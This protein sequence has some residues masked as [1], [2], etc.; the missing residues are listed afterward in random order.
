[1]TNTHS[2]S[3]EPFPLASV[4]TLMSIECASADEVH[5]AAADLE[6]A[7][8]QFELPSPLRAWLALPAVSS[9]LTDAAR[10]QLGISEGLEVHLQSRVVPM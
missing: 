1:M 4:D 2:A 8:Y 7:F 3:P 6:V 10:Q 9:C 5:I